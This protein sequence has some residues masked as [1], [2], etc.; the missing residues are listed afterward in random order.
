[1][2]REMWSNIFVGIQMNYRLPKIKYLVM[3]CHQ[4]NTIHNVKLAKYLGQFYLILLLNSLECTSIQAFKSSN[5]HPGTNHLNPP[6][7]SY[8]WLSSPTLNQKVIGEPY[9]NRQ[10]LKETAGSFS[11]IFG[12][13]QK[14]EV[15]VNYFK[16][17]FS[18]VTLA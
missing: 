5:V 16:I 1:M 17:E 7:P 18:M 10:P 4:W 9:G 15:Q 6:L 12:D 2:C 8:S 11:D 3:Q 14:Q 13:V